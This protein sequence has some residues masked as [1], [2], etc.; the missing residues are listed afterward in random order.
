MWDGGGSRVLLHRTQILAISATF[1]FTIAVVAC[2]R[3]DKPATTATPGITAPPGDAAAIRQV[4]FNKINDVQMLLNQAGSGSIEP[5][6]V[7][8]ADV[9]GDQREEAIIPISSGGT[10]GNLAYVVFTLKAGTP[11]KVLTRTLGRS[12]AGGLKMTVEDGK[13]VESSAEYGPSDPL[14]CPTVLKLTT[15]RWDGASLQV[16]GEQQVP[17]TP[18]PKQ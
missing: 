14:C 12:S 16:V 18:G 9:T 10:A 5:K 7:V 4:D 11:Q 15:F 6:T 1:L 8:F 2:G 3:G 13:L 17:L